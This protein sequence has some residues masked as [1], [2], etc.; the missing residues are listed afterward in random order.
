MELCYSIDD[1]NYNLTSIGDVLDD[2]RCEG[3]LEVGA[4]YYEADC[5]PMSASDVFSVSQF[6]EDIGE[7]MYDEVG[8]IADSYPSVSSE[9]REELKTFMLDWV[10]KHADPSRYWLVIGKSREKQVTAADLA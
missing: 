9:G 6:L 1:E 3:R 5:R 8:E 4:V 2:L 10:N 7:R